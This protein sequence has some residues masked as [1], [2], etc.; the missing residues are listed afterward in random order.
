MGTDRLGFRTEISVPVSCR[1]ATWAG[2]RCPP[3]STISI[4]GTRWLLA[5][6]AIIWRHP[7]GETSEN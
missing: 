6:M 1:D 7:P 3:L 5:R 4:Y 2:D